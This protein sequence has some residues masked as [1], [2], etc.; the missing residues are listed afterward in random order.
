MVGVPDGVGVS[1]P[2]WK[3]GRRVGL[4]QTQGKTPFFSDDYVRKKN[5]YILFIINT[6]ILRSTTNKICLINI[7]LE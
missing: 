5:C 3:T 6:K 1:M 7:V 4:N 2:D